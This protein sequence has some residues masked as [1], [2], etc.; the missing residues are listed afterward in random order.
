MCFAYYDLWDKRKETGLLFQ[1]LHRVIRLYN[2][3]WYCLSD[4]CSFKGYLTVDLCLRELEF[5]LVI[6]SCVAGRYNYL[7]P[8]TKIRRLS[9]QLY[10]Y[11]SDLMMVMIIMF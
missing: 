11:Q 4:G 5:T 7:I 6:L 3:R 8:V 2:I 10:V 1:S 9:K